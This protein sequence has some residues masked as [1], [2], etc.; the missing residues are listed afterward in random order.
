[1]MGR[2]MPRYEVFVLVVP[3]SL[4]CKSYDGAVAEGPVLRR[5]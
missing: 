1:M 3:R 4:A 5:S 2:I